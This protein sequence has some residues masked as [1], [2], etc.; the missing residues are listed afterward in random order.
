MKCTGCGLPLSPQRTHCPRCGKAAGESEE[1]SSKS[2]ETPQYAFP[3]SQANSVGGVQPQPATMAQQQGPD[4]I[5]GQMFLAA[6]TEQFSGQPDQMVLPDQ[7]Q[8]LQVNPSQKSD[9]QAFSQAKMATGSPDGVKPG[10][11]RP[12]SQNPGPA[13]SR[14]TIQ[15]GFTVAGLC[16]LSGGLI[17]ILVYLISLSL[18]PLI[19]ANPST[20]IAA[21]TP[22]SQA[23]SP[24]SQAGATVTP[25]LPLPTP[26]P[27][28]PGKVY[29]DNAQMG[30]SLNLNT[31]QL[32]QTSTT[33]T[34]NQKI[35][36]TFVLHP[37]TT[38]GAVCLNWYVNQKQ[39]SEFS[40]AVGATSQQ[41]YSFAFPT[42]AGSGS[43]SIYWASSPDCTD[44]ILAQVARFT[45]TP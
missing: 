23:S 34:V 37:L 32:S 42:S 26:T 3:S 27:G 41:A 10:E 9:W 43:V 20:A 30:S 7:G 29:I 44:K 2:A 19:A 28:L 6:G 39:F 16:V 38:G 1:K 25:T 14:R 11:F 12:S 4:N 21:H 13:H 8:T 45:V 17:L 40:F 22:A 36:V 18:P 35:F 31:A 15:S 24:A 33:F 5:P